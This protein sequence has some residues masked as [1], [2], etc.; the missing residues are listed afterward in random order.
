MTI[1]LYSLFGQEQMMMPYF[2]RYYAPQVDRLI[3]LSGGTD[4]E[5]RAH[6]VGMPRM[7]RF[8]ASPFSEHEL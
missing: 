3:M 7:P 5:T 4:E 8:T 1:W 2:L 6:G